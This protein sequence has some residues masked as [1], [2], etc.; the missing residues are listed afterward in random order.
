[1]KFRTTNLFMGQMIRFNLLPIIF[2][3][4]SSQIIGQTKLA[5]TGFGFLSVS[6][7]A[8]ASGMGEAVTTNNSIETSMYFNP[9]GLAEMT[10]KIYAGV[11][12]M[13]W[14]ADIKY[15]S[16]SAA[17]SPFEG[18]YGVFGINFMNI[19]YGKFDFTRVANNEQGFEDITGMPKPYAYD[20]NLTYGIR[21]S[22]EFSVGGRIKYA[23]QNLGESEIPIHRQ[24]IVD[25][26]LVPDTSIVKK[27]YSLDVLA[28]DFG[29]IYKTGFKSLT[30]GMSVTNFSRELK[31]ERES[32]QLPL[33][34]KFGISMN[35]MDFFPS[36][37][38][39]NSLILA[40]DAVHPRSYPEYLNIGGEYTF[41]QMI[42][43]RAGYITNHDDF[44]ISFG[45]GIHKFGF[46]FD[47]SWL[48]HKVF[49]NIQ[50]F[51]VGFSL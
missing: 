43:L 6:T 28:F 47:Y 39:S 11:S 44:G 36:L 34:F 48:A 3:L 46:N 37:A 10:S 2:L 19:D 29:T 32:F 1:M 7:D 51:S 45:F 41:M 25:S 42:A 4:I 31:Y 50:R 9:A 30:F 13:E 20:V 49:N 23:Y 12:Q 26:I 38:E 5:Q 24:V 22:E 16:A 17:Y 27:K 8:K 21:L 14:I 40:I 18:K 35:L 15:F 33:T